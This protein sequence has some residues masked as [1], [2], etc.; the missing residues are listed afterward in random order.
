M[1][2]LLQNDPLHLGPSMFGCPFCNKIMR[3]RSD[4]QNHI[5]IH[6]GEK[7]FNCTMC[8]YKAN[9]R[10]AIASHINRRHRDNV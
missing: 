3:K 1:T 7:P 5:C 2:L 10:S 8:G 6:T 4:M 9:Q